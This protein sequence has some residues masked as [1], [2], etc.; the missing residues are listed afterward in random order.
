MRE[1]LVLPGAGD[2]ARYFQI[3]VPVQPR[4][5]GVRWLAGNGADT[6]LDF[7]PTTRAKAAC[8]LTPHPPQ[9]KSLA[10]G[11]LP[12]HVNYAVKSSYLLG[13]LESVPE[14]SVKLKEPETRERKFEEVMKS[15]EQAA[16]LVLV[17]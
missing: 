15:T 17:C 4:G 16:V 7:L 3:R 8:A 1:N 14:V 10:S 12:E 13:F 11:A 6:A 5:F 2:D 9:S